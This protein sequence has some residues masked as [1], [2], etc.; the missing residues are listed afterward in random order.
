[1]VLAALELSLE[2]WLRAALPLTPEQGDVSFEP[3]SGT[4]GSAISR[5]TVNLFLH[6]ITRSGQPD[7]LPPAR[8]NRDGD[9]VAPAPSPRMAFA[10]LVSAWAGGVRDEHLLIGDVLR[11]VLA[12]AVIP[13]EH[14]AEGVQGTVELRLGDSSLG[15]VKDVWNGV[16][17]RF[18]VCLTLVVVAQVPTVEHVVAPAVSEVEAAV[19]RPAAPLPGNDRGRTRGD[20]VENVGPSRRLPGGRVGSGEPVP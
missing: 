17:G 8:E 11:A 13:P 16:D 15:R 5:P 12:T 20:S 3:P 2:R 10:Y 14:L 19:V 18:R 1:M 9:L 4:W 7:V 6:E